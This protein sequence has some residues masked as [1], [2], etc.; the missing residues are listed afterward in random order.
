[1]KKILVFI[2]VVFGYLSHGQYTISG[3]QDEYVEIEDYESMFFEKKG[4]FLTWTHKFELDFEFPYFEFVFDHLYCMQYGYCFFSEYPSGI[5]FNSFSYLFD[6]PIDTHNVVSDVRFDQLEVD[7]VK[8]LVIQFTK[9]RLVTDTS[10]EEYDS[11]VNFQCWF[12]EDGTIEIRYGPSNLDNSPSYIP[13]K[14]FALVLPDTNIIAGPWVALYH[15]YDT[16]KV[17][18][19]ID[20]DSHEEFEI[21]D[22]TVRPLRWWPPDGWVIRFENDYVGSDDIEND[23]DDNIH[24]YP[25]PVTDRISISS[26]KYIESISIMTLDG[27]LLKSCTS[28]YELDI[29][30][31]R[32]GMYL[33]KVVVGDNVSIKKIIKI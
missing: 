25:N 22:E 13:G 24:I 26:D 33:V 1:M 6:N 23:I 30:E 3:F 31:I 32:S 18:S 19:Y 11:H 28:Q 2:L 12:Y 17:I 14:G 4:A 10:V 8:A 9:N 20:V 7:G 16:S 27:K 29:A 5:H 15:P 21:V